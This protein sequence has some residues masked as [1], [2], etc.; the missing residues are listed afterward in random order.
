MAAATLEVGYRVCVVS[1]GPFHGLKGTVKQVHTIADSHAA[2]DTDEVF[3]FYYVA[4][5]AVQIKEPVWFQNSEVE[6]LT[7]S[8]AQA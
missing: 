2:H 1:Y 3:C 8:L 6:P 4:L 5:D 7:T